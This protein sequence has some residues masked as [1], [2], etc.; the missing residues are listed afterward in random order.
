M[1]RVSHGFDGCWR[2][3]G[4]AVRGLQS[5]KRFCPSADG[6]GDT[7]SSSNL[8]TMTP[9]T[10]FPTQSSSA[11]VGHPC[12]SPGNSRTPGSTPGSDLAVHS[13]TS[14]E[15][16][17][18]SP[19]R[20]RTPRHR[21]RRGALFHNTPTPARAPSARIEREIRQGKPYPNRRS[22]TQLSNAH[23]K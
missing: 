9:S 3:S 8:S 12:R 11:S 21:T 15:G 4:P 14:L 20:R 6:G 16:P 7:S 1:M 22:R 2:E 10:T 13:T 19:P 17:R 23:L 18:G 5:L